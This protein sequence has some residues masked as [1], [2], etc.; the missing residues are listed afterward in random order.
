MGFSA[1]A[2][3]FLL[4]T[5]GIALGVGLYT[6]RGEH[7][8]AIQDALEEQ[9]A[10]MDQDIHTS[11]TI[12]KYSPPGDVL[13][14]FTT[15]RRVDKWA[16]YKSNEQTN[17]PSTGPF[18]DGETE[19]GNAMYN[20]IDTSDDDWAS[21]SI[22]N[23]LYATHHFLFTIPQ[24]LSEIYNISVL[25][26]GHGTANPA[27]V[28]IWNYASSAWELIG[29]APILGS[30]NVVVKDLVTGS[31]SP[32]DY[33]DSNNFLH[34]VALS[35]RSGPPANLRTDY[36]R[37]G[38]SYGGIWVENTGEST[39]DPEYL[40]LFDNGAFV[41]LPGSAFT[42]DGG[43][44]EPGEILR[45]NYSLSVLPRQVKVAAENGVSDTYIAS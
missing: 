27:Y 17:P 3:F 44:W 20:N 2:A 18:I 36:V 13:Y 4:I 11:I 42:V 45:V 35:Q 16:A 9:A 12:V 38:V 30:D 31:F 32:A 33:V 26:E 14:D 24:N 43:Y 5:T 21:T 25:W 29:T 15:G 7:I 28:Y 1:S 37:V 40:V 23:G 10:K 34:I 19:F 39:L 22:N 6:T 41:S 8:T